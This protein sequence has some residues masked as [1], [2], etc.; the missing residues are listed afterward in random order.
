MIQLT[1]LYGKPQ[2]PTSFDRHYQETH[3]KLAQKIPGLK[4]YTV[5]K[6]ASLNP[7]E[8]SPYYLIADLYF[9]NMAALQ[10]ALQSPEGQAAAGDL[11]NFASGGA[12]LLAG[13]VSTYTP[14]SIG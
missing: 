10:A 9:E 12:T 1:V 5:S 7:Q 8:P 11:Q 4:G 3:A 13:E 14:V 6:P 2:D